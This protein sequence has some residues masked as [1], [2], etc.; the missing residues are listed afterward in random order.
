MTSMGRSQDS[1][2]TRCGRIIGWVK[3]EAV[4]CT[5]LFCALLSMAAVPPDGAY[6]GYLDMRVLSLLFCLMLVVGGL[7]E[8]GLLRCLARR[9]LSGRKRPRLLALVLVL[10]P[11]FTA[12]LMT[13]DVALLTFVPFAVLVLDLTGQ[14]GRL[15]YLVALQ[16]VA[17]NLGSMA[18]PVG[19]PQNLYLCSRYHIPMGDF[20]LTVLP[21]AAVSLAGVCAAAGAVGGE[22]IDVTFLDQGEGIRNRK[23][24]GLMGLLFFLCLLSVFRLLPWPVLL[25][26]VVLAT[27]LVARPLFGKVDYGLLATFVCFFVFSG[28]LGRI[29]GVQRLAGSL[30]EEHAV[31]T[32][33]LSSQ[34]ISNVPAAILLS[35]FTEDWRG[36]LIGTNV[37]GLGTLVASLASLISFQSYT[38]VRGARPAYYLGVFTLVNL[39]GL[40]LLGAAVW[41]LYG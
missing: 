33:V 19:N 27:L 21:L 15:P 34:V 2:K 30:L 7:E 13:N 31:L 8:C 9:L 23:Q 20:F 41:L 16:T 38:R 11:F 28:N 14:S 5:A 32:A 25:G 3:R 22:S 17:A 39:A 36:L 37:G 26:V 24:L 10:L 1:F 29:E 18:T 12:M 4:L 40:V 6:T 35:R